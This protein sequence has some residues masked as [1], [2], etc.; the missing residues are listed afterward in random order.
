MNIQDLIKYFRLSL[1]IMSGGQGNSDLLNL[2]DKDI[3]L[4]L[5][6]ALA[7]FPMFQDLG[8]LQAKY[9]PLFMLYAKKEMYFSLATRDAGLFDIG[10]DN[11]NYLKRSQKFDHYMKI[12]DSLNDEIEA[13]LNGN[14]IGLGTNTLTSFDVLLPSKVRT[15]RYYEKGAVPVLYLFIK[16][17]EKDFVEIEWDYSCSHYGYVEVYVSKESVFDKN[18]L[19]KTIKDSSKRVALVTDSRKNA[20]RVVD[21]EKETEY[22]LTLRIVDR[23]GLE[24][25]V[26]KIFVTPKD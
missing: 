2:E 11:N 8:D 20:L 25:V 22:Y 9:L 5:K 12:I 3:E 19:K 13:M 7:N 21:L 24:S 10:A 6:V 17:V 16:K 23:S 18:A 15:L 4:F 1:N 26:E 14:G